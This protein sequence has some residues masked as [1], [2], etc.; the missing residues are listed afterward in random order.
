MTAQTE[1]RAVMALQEQYPPERFNLL[2]PT[3][4]AVD[5]TQWHRMSVSIVTI[6]PDPRMGDVYPVASRMKEGPDGKPVKD[7]NR[8][9]YED[10]FSLARPATDRIGTA[11]GINYDPMQSKIVSASGDYVAYETVGGIRRPDGSWV[12]FKATKEIDLRAIEMEIREKETNRLSLGIWGEDAKKAAMLYD[13]TWGADPNYPTS[14][15]FYIAPK[16]MAR[17]IEDKVRPAMI[18]WRKNKLMRAETGARLRVIRGLL[19]IRMQFTAQELGL[20]FAVPRIDFVPDLNDPDVKRTVLATAAA[21]MGGLYGRQAVVHIPQ[22]AEVHQVQDDVMEA[23]FVD[24]GPAG[25]QA[26]QAPGGTPVT[27][28]SAPT[29]SERPAASVQSSGA[30]KSDPQADELVCTD[31]G[32]KTP[33]NVARYSRQKYGRILCYTCQKKGGTQN[34]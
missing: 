18:Q 21:A 11:A 26:S 23:D 2:L 20:P 19:G 7:G 4:A 5:V 17:A 1:S 22:D 10:L 25:A 32:A 13:G 27:D 15:R 8:N 12:A 31:C 34:G 28:E 6:N 33:E 3:T 29:A 16:D 24:H 30:T 9:V 14:Q